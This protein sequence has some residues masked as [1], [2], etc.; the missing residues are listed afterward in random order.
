MA[1]K[2]KSTSSWWTVL[3]IVAAVALWAYN[4][5]QAISPPV[6]T[7]VPRSEKSAPASPK[8]STPK[9]AEI[10]KIGGF[11]V[12]RKCTLVEN[13]GNDG[14]SFTVNLPGGGEA[15]LRLYFVDT[16]E[17]AFKTY[18]DGDDNHQRIAEQAN[19]FGDISD[20]AVVEVGQE[21][22]K[23]TLAQLAARP[24]DI[25]TRW[26]NP[27]NDGRYHAFI[28]VKPSGKSRLL[29][30]LLVEKGLVRIHTK[31]ADLP[32]G[33]SAAKHKAYLKGLENAA[34]KGKAGAWG[35]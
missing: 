9:P 1:I 5:K 30:E 35:K 20:D 15:I 17:S 26:D 12:F 2:A 28:E 23:F 27:F 24:F 10:E 18:A 13:R 31:G 34:R 21:A 25:F 32:D 7:P 8:S 29:H 14:D 4:Q 22:K 6:K 11:Q 3:V 19:Y 16:P 33:T